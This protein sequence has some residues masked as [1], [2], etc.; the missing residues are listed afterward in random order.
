MRPKCIRFA[1][2]ASGEG[3]MLWH[4]ALISIFLTDTI[5]LILIGSSALSGLAI[6]LHWQPQSA[7]RRQIRLERL[8]ETA[9]LKSRWGFIFFLFSSLLLMVAVTC[10]LPDLVPGAMCGKGV[11][12]A[13]AGNGTQALFF[14]WLALLLLFWQR[15]LARQNN[16]Q[17][18][19]P[20]TLAWARLLLIGAPVV[21]MAGF[22]TA[23]AFIQLN[24]HQPVSCCVQVYQQLDS[25]KTV[26]AVSGLA[27]AAWLVLY[28]ALGF[29]LTGLSLWIAAAPQSKT[30]YRQGLLCCLSLVWVMVAALGL[31]A[32]LTP[33]I[34]QVLDHHC[35]FCLFLPEHCGIGFPLFALMAFVSAEGPAALILKLTIKRH[36][37]LAQSANRRL[38]V[39]ALRVAL[40]VILFSLLALLPAVLWRLR[41]GVW[42]QG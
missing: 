24:T 15:M 20:L 34:Y 4:P 25:G 38:G 19:A 32:F 13:T 36:P 21:A 11:M 17:P 8:A 35:L 3:L 1:G 23:S 37:L 16:L 7:H 39:A 6:V 14:R 41:F 12:Q 40:A 18:E 42:I 2:W 28:S 9:D 5:A 10:L 22:D 33:Y 27:A 29:A 31:M 30:A 26:S